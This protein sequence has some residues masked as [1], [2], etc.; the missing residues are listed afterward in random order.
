MA[1]QCSQDVPDRV[2]GIAF[3]DP[4]A[5]CQKLTS[6]RLSGVG[7]QRRVDAVGDDRVL[8]VLKFVMGHEMVA[9]P[10]AMASAAPNGAPVSAACRPSR[11]GAR[12]RISVPPTSGMR[13]IPTSGIAI[14][15]VS[16]TTRTL[17]WA[18]IPTPPPITM[19]SISATYGLGKRP[20]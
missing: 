1:S 17:P 13:P 5:L 12:D 18:L 20:I 7:G 3:V 19:P 10:S 15:V 14:L 16:V 6:R 8:E 11:P 4:I 2:T 9:K